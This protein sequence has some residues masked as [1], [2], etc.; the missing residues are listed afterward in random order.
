M[1]TS[2]E[3]ERARRASFNRRAFILFGAQV[4]VAGAIGARLHQ[5]QVVETEAYATRAERN[6]VKT[7]P[8]APPRGEI[9]DR[10]GL[11]LAVNRHN[12]GVW[13]VRER[14]EDIETTMARLERIIALSDREK[15]RLEK[16]FRT[17][18]AFRPV[19]VKD[20][21]DWADFAQIEANAPGLAGVEPRVTWTRHYPER[22]AL[23]HVI[24]YVAALTKEERA[25]DRTNNPLLRV[26]GL[27]VGK[28][29]VERSAERRLRG[30]AG[31]R[32]TERMAGGREVREI[33]RDEGRRGENLTMSIDLGL[34]R[35]A[36]DRLTGES[37]AAVVMDVITGDLLAI[38]SAP[39]YDPNL[40][41][42]GI[43]HA[44]WNALRENELD[45]L[46]NKA[47]AGA[48]PP[49][50]TYKMLTGL[51]ALEHEVITPQTRIFCSGKIR[52]GN[53][54]FHCW[55]RGGHGSMNFKTGL[56]H[57]CDVYYYELAQ[58]V[59]IDR[60][61]ALSRNFGVGVKPELELP[62]LAAGNMPTKDWMFAMR[63]RRWSRGDTVNVGI[64]Q[65][66]LLM[67]PL[68]LAVMTARLANGKHQL[69][70]RIVRGVNGEP[71]P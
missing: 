22:D 45:P 68:Q 19:P 49:G 62:N 39:A 58:R 6:R 12:Y 34:Q 55:K 10:T 13:I 9:F 52:V 37:A 46:R 3:M 41:V 14:A 59:G 42:T 43:S 20:N 47:L 63:G 21:L 57:S 67:S 69:S 66:A 70:P 33:A 30:A 25:R 54:T 5:L 65:G 48:Y 26:E 60:L 7:E 1:M 50:S 11:P 29:G 38:A 40:F 15:R 24:G 16:A 36:M 8:L 51:A 61:A 23:A 4:G 17:E 28:N 44:D 18:P 71:E 53:L 56:K 27:M 64:G 2:D 31:V 35:Y 32:K